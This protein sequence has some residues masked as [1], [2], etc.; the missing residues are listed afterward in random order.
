[1]KHERT[2]LISAYEQKYWHVL[3]NEGKDVPV[4]AVE[5]RKVVRWQ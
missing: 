5:V 3:Q 2:F 4:I 1:M